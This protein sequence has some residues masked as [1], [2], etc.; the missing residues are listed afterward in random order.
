MRVGIRCVHSAGPCEV[1]VGFRP[2][3]QVKPPHRRG[4]AGTRVAFVVIRRRSE[5]TGGGGGRVGS[6]RQSNLAEERGLDSFVS[7][8]FWW[9]RWRV[10][11]ASLISQARVSGRDCRARRTG[12]R[13][14]GGFVKAHHALLTR[15]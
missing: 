5:A 15:C 13:A 7:S 9:R 2:M 4:C 12:R 8:P 11:V 10:V 3:T 6:R 1:P 14:D